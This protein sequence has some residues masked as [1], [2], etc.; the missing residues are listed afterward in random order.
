MVEKGLTNAQARDLYEKGY[1]NDIQ[2]TGEKSVKAIVKENTVT[3]FNMVFVVLALLLVIVGRF[4]D[5]TFL[6]IAIINSVI[7]IIQQIRSQKALAKLKVISANKVRVLRDKKI[8]EVDARFLVKGDVIELTAGNQIP[9]DGVVIS[10]S[11]R[12][13]EALLTGEIDTIN[14]TK[15]N[16][17]MS[18]SFVVSGKCFA[19]MEKVGAESYAAQLT[20]QAKEHRTKK[21]TGMMQSLDRLIKVIG[22]A[23]I[24]IGIALFYNGFVMNHQAFHDVIPST[25]AALIGMIPEGLYLLTSM[26]LAVSVM[27]LSKEKVLVHDMAAIETLARVDVLCV[28]KTGTIT[29]TDM[30]VEN[31]VCF[32]EKKY[33]RT[34]VMELLSACYKELEIENDTGKAMAKYFNKDCK[35]S[36]KKKIPFSSVHKWSAVEFEEHGTCY[37]GAADFLLGDEYKSIE[38]LIDTYQKQGNRVIL[39]AI[40]EQ[41]LKETQLPDDIEKVAIVIIENPIRSDAVETFQ[42]FAEQGV[43]IKVISGDNP[44]SVSRIAMHAEIE[45]ADKYIDASVLKEEK[46]YINAVKEYS[47]FG[48]VTPE[49]KRKI[50]KALQQ[51]GHTVAMTGDGVNDVLALKDADCGIAMAS[52]T[53]AAC[54]VAELVLVESKFSV[55]PKVVAEGR[56]VINNIERSAALY[57]VKNIMSLFL[58][59][60]TV[61]LGFPYPF[62]PI[63]LTF[64]SAVTIGIPSFLLALE[65]NHDLVKGKFMRNVLRKALPGGLTNIVLLTGIELFAVAFAFDQGTLSTLSTV[66]MCFVGLMVLYYISKPLDIKRWALLGS[67]T[68]AAVICISN[69][70]H[71]FDM[72]PLNFQSILVTIVFLLLVPTVMDFF[73]RGFEKAGQVLDKLEPRKKCK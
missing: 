28:D 12:V 61:F 67:M 9:A 27:R 6:I 49:Q 23:L 10:G 50:I 69:Y 13:N 55:L 45:N 5:M 42:Y 46:D 31:Y 24:P 29:S 2:D 56:R 34:F 1:G 51:D 4:T 58:S 52:G 71:L 62:V 65:P 44:A 59:L 63:Q 20:A 73:E 18:G 26:A 32:Q 7:G 37:I 21:K 39:V 38:P 19:R 41:E 17:I 3:F 53:Q 72:A 54:Q 14:K 57:L 16:E 70:N 36:V 11:I 8:R 43:S 66:I 30:K 48:R 47:V 22:F 68:V 25:V 35:W 15:G 40:S 64:V 33:S 60:I